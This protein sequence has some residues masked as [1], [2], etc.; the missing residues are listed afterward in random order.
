M[1]KND[2]DQSIQKRQ[3]ESC[4]F[5]GLVSLRFWCGIGGI[6]GAGSGAVG[7]GRSR[8]GIGFA[9][10]VSGPGLVFTIVGNIPAASLEH[11]GRI[12]DQPG[13]CSPAYGTDHFPVFKPLL[14]F[15]K[16]L[17]AVI[18]PVFIDGH[19]IFLLTGK[20]I[21]ITKIIK[22]YVKNT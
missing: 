13:R 21:K 7:R 8:S 4:L 15:L 6:A 9:V 10:S 20:I 14:P 17:L 16:Y 12:G 11:K 5:C 19:Y 3:P 18:T 1:P 2:E 22:D